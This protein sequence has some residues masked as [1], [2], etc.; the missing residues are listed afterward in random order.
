MG[1]RRLSA[2]GFR[3]RRR[4]GRPA[5]SRRYSARRAYGRGSYARRARRIV[6]TASETKWVDNVWTRSIGAATEIVSI[7]TAAAIANPSNNTIFDNVSLGADYNQRIAAKVYAKTLEIRMTC[8]LTDTIANF[9]T[10]LPTGLH[11]RFWCVVDKYPTGSNWTMSNIFQPDGAG[12]YYGVSLLRNRTF[13]QRYAIIDQ[14][15][16]YMSPGMPAPCKCDR[17]IKLNKVVQLITGQTGMNYSQHS[18]N[19]I[20]VF[21]GLAEQTNT[22]TNIF[23]MQFR[24]RTLWK[25]I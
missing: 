9:Q 24:M 8:V 7:G 1:Y 4:F 2:R 21:Y 13:L 22:A 15:D 10:K 16:M 19:A 17:Y 3:S 12:N 18:R 20:M 11:V 6:A 5:S 25:E 23:Q 14:W